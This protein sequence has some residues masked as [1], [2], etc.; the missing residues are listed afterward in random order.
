MKDL[1]FMDDYRRFNNLIFL[2][3]IFTNIACDNFKLII[4]LYNE[5]DDARMQEYIYC[6]EKNIT[7]KYI[8]E[9][10]VVYDNSKD[11]DQNKLLN[12][13]K[14]KKCKIEYI[15][16]RSTFSY[17]FNLANE[18]Y[19]NQKII[20]SNGDIYFDDTLQLLDNFDFI[21]KLVVLTRWD[22]MADGSLKLIKKLSLDSWIF[23]TPIKKFKSDFQ[24][25]VPGCEHSI[26]YYAILSDLKLLNPSLSIKSVHVHQ[27]E[28]R[29]YQKRIDSIP[30]PAD[31]KFLM[32]GYIND[33][34]IN[35][36]QPSSKQ[37]SQNNS[38]QSNFLYFTTQK[39]MPRIINVY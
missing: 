2:I 33:L 29:N 38:T 3:L 15:T 25:G 37:N 34:I 26:T 35:Q 10:L 11:D 27:T 17:C 12:Y 22:I 7:N 16:G 9:I 19:P 23:K 36:F 5:V 13:L 14:A 30:L 32:Q 18:I 4:P 20:L 21:G 1:R 28:K 6:F 8:D 39:R 31:H 24:M